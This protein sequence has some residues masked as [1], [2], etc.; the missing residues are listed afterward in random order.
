[1]TSGSELNDKRWKQN[2][3]ISIFHYYKVTNITFNNNLSLQLQTFQYELQTFCSTKLANRCLSI[4]DVKVFSAVRQT[5]S[6]P[7]SG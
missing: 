7:P 6:R 5:V 4:D 1:M 2:V 3:E